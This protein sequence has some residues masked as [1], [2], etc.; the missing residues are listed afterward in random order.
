MRT[1]G[2]WNRPV[3][4][5]EQQQPGANGGEEDNLDDSDNGPKR[6]QL[7]QYPLDCFG[8]QN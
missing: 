1:A 8:L 4:H 5:L 7:P 3:E 6:V 2:Q